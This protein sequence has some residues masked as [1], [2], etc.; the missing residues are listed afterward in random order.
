MPVRKPS[1]KRV[2]YLW[3]A[4][5]TQAEAQNIGARTSLLMGDTPQF[6]D[7]I[8]TRILRRAGARVMASYGL[9]EAVDIEKLISLLV[10]SGLA[11]HIDL[12][13]KLRTHYFGELRTSLVTARVHDNPQ[14]AIRLL[15]MHNDRKF[16]R[17]VESL[18]GIITTNHD[19]LLQIAFQAVFGEL[20][21]G[22]SFA[23]ADFAPATLISTPP[24]VQLHGSFTWQFAV[25]MQVSPLTTRS[26][27]SRNTVW[28]PPTTLKESK[29]YP[30][31]RL[32]A[33][34]YEL[35]AERCD[36]LRVVG[37]S[38][39]Q[40]DWNVLSLIFNAQRHREF[41]KGAPFKIELIMPQKIGER[42]AGECAYLRHLTPIGFLTDGEFAPYKD[43]DIPP[44]S[45]MANPFGYWL[46]EKTEFHSA[47]DE[48]DGVEARMPATEPAGEGT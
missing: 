40:N 43:Q 14:L 27:Y 47:R 32:S 48:F 18:S 1:P 37:A 3:G 31:N 45:D 17:E 16:E 21:L 6:G 10:V 39:T 35:L 4:G 19:G 8:T 26:K 11:E 20:N 15:E 2:V 44:E 36:V 23:S 9:G 25:P 13:E 46:S 41:V 34:A 24:L 38:L 5:A 28:I 7:G 12:A 30:F 42:I 33:L 29:Q 22:L